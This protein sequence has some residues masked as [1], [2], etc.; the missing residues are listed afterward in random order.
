MFQ[1]LGSYE[2]CN[3]IDDILVEEAVR[4]AEVHGAIT[5]IRSKIEKSYIVGL[6]DIEDEEEGYIPGIYAD[7]TEEGYVG[8]LPPMQ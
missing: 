5:E 1:E 2:S 7:Q 3:I 6:I 4:D 8:F